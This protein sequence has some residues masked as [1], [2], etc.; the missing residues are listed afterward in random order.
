MN[1]FHM[2]S[3]GADMEEG[4]LIEWLKKPGDLVK[5]GDVVAVVETQKGAIEVEIFQEGTLS[6]FLVAPGT[7]VPVGAPM[8][9]LEEGAGAAQPAI[10]PRPDAKTAPKAAELE[11]AVAAKPS[12]APGAAEPPKMA[13]HR[14]ASAGRRKISPAARKLAVDLGLDLET[15]S[16][17]GPDG[18]IVFVD[19]ERAI[20]QPGEKG[21]PP[22]PSAARVAQPQSEMRKAIAAAM[23]RSK[24]EI[25]HYYLSHTL[26]IFAAQEW[27]VQSN[28][29]RPPAERVLFAALLIKATAKAAAT[30]PGFNGFYLKNGFQ[31]RT[32][33][34]VGMAISTRGGGLI[35]PGIRNADTI[36]LTEIME[37][38][39][40]LV[41]RTR[42]GRLR[43]S[44]LTDPT[45]TIS[46]LGERGVD[47]LYGVIHPPQVAIVGFGASA[48]R[49]WVVDGA[50]VARPVLT[51]TLAADHRVTDGHYGSQ[52]LSAVA[53]NLHSPEAL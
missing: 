29:A 1:L 32:D 8:A 51:M 23:S 40:D 19:V 49:P 24:R 39:R 3:L 41:T 52:F 11:G 25:P 44:E 34:N 38:L 7:K 14:P 31:P 15:I 22:L 26:D 10:G 6:K 35:A 18:A 17:S 2:P 16:G 5:R 47:T 20:K 28:S 33:V 4:T 9:E 27:L 30:T 37:K 36:S 45:I 46:S 43:S 50:V 12:V 48:V 53:T 21:K 13:E 42:T